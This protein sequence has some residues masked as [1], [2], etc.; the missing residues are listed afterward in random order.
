VGI[1]AVFRRAL[2]LPVDD[3]AVT[4]ELSSCEIAYL[5]GGKNLAV[6][7]AVARL[8]YEKC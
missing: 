6:S 5:A 1:A 3:G 8:V 2:R 7:T 4:P